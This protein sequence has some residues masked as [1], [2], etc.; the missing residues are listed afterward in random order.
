MKRPRFSLR[1]ATH[2]CDWD[3]MIN[4]VRYGCPWAVRWLR[5][6]HTVALW[7]WDATKGMRRKP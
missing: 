1:A 7:W 4:R 6:K 2:M 5:V 3:R